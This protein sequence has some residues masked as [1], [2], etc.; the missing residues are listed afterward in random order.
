MNY[1]TYVQEKKYLFIVIY[2]VL[3]FFDILNNAGFIASLF[4]SIIQTFSLTTIWY[5]V[6]SVFNE[7]ITEKK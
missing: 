2:F 7:R 5:A 3:V 4:T 1:L 6:E